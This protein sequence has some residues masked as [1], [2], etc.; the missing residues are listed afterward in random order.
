[1]TTIQEDYDRIYNGIDRSRG[2][3]S[4]E[5]IE[6]IRVVNWFDGQEDLGIKDFKSKNNI[7][8]MIEVDSKER[9]SILRILDKMMLIRVLRMNNNNRYYYDEDE[10]EKFFKDHPYGK[11]FLT[12]ID[13]RLVYFGDRLTK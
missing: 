11:Q 2:V 7:A 3:S 9:K 1:M 8:S 10:F 5:L 4:T 13:R 12:Y 6:M